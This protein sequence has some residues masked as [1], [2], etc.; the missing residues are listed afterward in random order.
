MHAS[1]PSP[2]PHDCAH[3]FLTAFWQR[4][5]A[6]LDPSVRAGISLLAQTG[7]EVIRPGLADAR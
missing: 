1:R 4:P 6:Y 2:V 3:G 7:D 5:E